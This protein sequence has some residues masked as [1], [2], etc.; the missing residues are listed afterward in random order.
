MLLQKYIK[1][2]NQNFVSNIQVP[3]YSKQSIY[4]GKV[5]LFISDDK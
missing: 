4:C 5:I 3:K 2:N 1:Q